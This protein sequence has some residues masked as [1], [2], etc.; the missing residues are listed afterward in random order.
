M[1]VFQVLSLFRI[2]WVGGSGKRNRKLSDRKINL[3]EI[4]YIL[5]TVADYCNAVQV[6]KV[7]EK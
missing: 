6:L 1:M 4:F 5:Y 3:T 2:I 7:D